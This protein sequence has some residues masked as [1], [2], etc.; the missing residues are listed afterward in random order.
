MTETIDKILRVSQEML[1]EMG[2][3]PTPTEVA[4]RLQMPVDRVRQVLK[5][6]TGLTEKEERI[7]RHKLT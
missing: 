3:E 4:T 7:L 1:K 5:L 6:R 2:R